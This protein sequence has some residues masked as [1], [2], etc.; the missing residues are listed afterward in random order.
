[1]EK[2]SH[3]LWNAEEVSGKINIKRTEAERD[4]WTEEEK[5]E[6]DNSLHRAMW[7]LVASS[8]IDEPLF[9]I[10]L[11]KSLVDELNKSAKALSDSGVDLP[12]IPS[13][14]ELRKAYG[15]E[16]I[17]MVRDHITAG[18]KA[19]KISKYLNVPLVLAY[20]IMEGY[21]DVNK[22]ELRTVISSIRSEGSKVACDRFGKIAGEISDIFSECAEYGYHKISVDE[23]SKAYWLGLLGPS[24]IP[25]VEDVKKRVRADLAGSYFQKQGADSFAVEYYK[26]L[27]GNELGELITKGVTKKKRIKD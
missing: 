10:S 17:D 4:D 13:W 19:R 16:A 15:T 7:G 9:N 24:A 6:F 12:Y 21:K 11:D 18:I 2:A 27:Y 25:M 20:D 3:H 23:A 8:I 14:G 22:E 26:K 5:A 1:M